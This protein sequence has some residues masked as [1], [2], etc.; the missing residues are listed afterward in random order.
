MERVSE[1]ERG[2]KLLCTPC[3]FVYQLSWPLSRYFPPDCTEEVIYQ[4]FRA[5]THCSPMSL[6]K[7]DRTRRA[8]R[9]YRT[10]FATWKGNDEAFIIIIIML[11]NWWFP[12]VC[13]SEFWVLPQ[14]TTMKL[15]FSKYLACLLSPLDNGQWKLERVTMMMMTI[16]M[17][18]MMATA[19]AA[20]ATTSNREL[21]YAACKRA[22]LWATVSCRHRTDI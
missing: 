3:L 11:L 20:L 18:V 2:E 9:S 15:D 14:A 17:M 16:V 6:N 8:S 5:A 21:D 4:M 19:E 1:K 22:S 13:L 7:N 12:S 10:Q